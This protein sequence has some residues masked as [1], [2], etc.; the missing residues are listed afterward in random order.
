MLAAMMLLNI[1]C[2]PVMAYEGESKPDIIIE[3]G[4]GYVS[5]KADSEE[6]KSGSTISEGNIWIIT[7]IGV[8]AAIAIAVIA[9]KKKK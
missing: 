1:T 9:F 2:F 3:N 4:T 6:R 5:A 7:G 8:A